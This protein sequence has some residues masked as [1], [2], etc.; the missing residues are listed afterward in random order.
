MRLHF[1]A[2]GKGHPGAFQPFLFRFPNHGGIFPFIGPLVAVESGFQVFPTAADFS[3]QQEQKAVGLNG[4]GFGQCPEKAGQRGIG[5]MVGF[6][7]KGRIAG[8]SLRFGGQSPGQIPLCFFG[9]QCAPFF[10]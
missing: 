5:F 4:L 3:P 10:R 1:P 2:L 6:L 8:R 9:H 7:G